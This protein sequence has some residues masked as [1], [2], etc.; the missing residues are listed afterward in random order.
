MKKFCS[1]FAKQNSR[2][3]TTLVALALVVIV[4]SLLNPRYATYDNLVDIIQQGVVNAFLAM[5]I[6]VAILTAGIDLSIGSTMAVVLVTCATLSA[7][8]VNVFFTILVGLAV[9]AFIGMIN[10]FLVTKM[11]LQPFIAT[12]GMM[13]TLRGVAYIISGG[14]PVLNVSAEF[15]EFFQFQLVRGVRMNMIYM[16]LIA[17]IYGI[18]LRRKRLGIYIYAIGSNE[19]ATKLSGINVNKYKTIAYVL[20]GVCAAIAGMVTMARLGTGEPTAGQGDET[21]AIAAAAI[22]GTSLAGGKG[23]MAGTVLGAFT[24]SALRIGLIVV[25][26]D[27][28][29][30]YVAI[31]LI[32]L[33]ATYIENLQQIVLRLFRGKKAEEKSKE[34]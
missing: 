32:I 24:L 23:S 25:G 12:L 15:R 11:K 2:E 8:G 4:F 16:F 14:S 19:E 31:G 18:I 30:Q 20:C 3:I 5:G 13:E 26:M 33:L 17:L 6:T 10:G 7:N 29:Y 22:G 28:F 27:T 21:M 34:F 1:R 9:G